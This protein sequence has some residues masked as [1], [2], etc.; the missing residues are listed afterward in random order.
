VKQSGG[1][2]AHLLLKEAPMTPLRFLSVV[3]LV[4]LAAM[5]SASAQDQIGPA[6]SE[7]VAL[8][9]NAWNF[10]EPNSVPGF[11]LL[12]QSVDTWS[13]MPQFSIADSGRRETFMQLA[14]R[15]LKLNSY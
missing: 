4:T 8:A 2:Y 10:N 15:K 6:A 12:P 9:E 5:S 11:G 7:P 1:Q 3:S 13:L 14:T